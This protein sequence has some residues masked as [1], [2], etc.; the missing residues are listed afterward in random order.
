MAG[1][2][3][4]ALALVVIALVSFAA[5]ATAQRLPRTATPE[6]Y[7]L[8]F[9]VDI[10]HARFEGTETIRVQVDV[11][12]TRIVVNAA[13]IHFASVTI[14]AGAATQT[15]AVTLDATRDTATFVVPTTLPKGPAAIHIRYAGILN[16][17]LRGFYLSAGDSRN[18]A[19]T[20]FESTDARRA[21]P[22]FDEPAFKA[23]F[24]VTLTID[25]SDMAI[26][27]GRVIADMPGPGVAQHTVT[28]STTP[29][30]SS[31]LV[32]MAVG[33]FECLEA[34]TDGVPIRICTSP[35]KTALGQIALQSAQQILAYYNA[36][37]AIRYPYGKLDVLAVPDF[38]SGAMEN[39]AAIFFREI[40]LLADNRTASTDTRKDIASGL[41]HEMAHQWFG[42]LVTMRWWDDLWLNEGFATW[43]A[44]RPL[45]SMKPEW[46]IP[47]DEAVENQAALGLDALRSTRPVHADVNTPAEI[48]AAFDGI[49]YEKGAAVLRMIERYVG[50]ATFRDGINAYLQAHSYGNATSQDFWRAIATTSGK[51]I[52]R[53]M[54]T[55]I[56]QPGAPL[57]SV[58]TT[59]VGSRTRV[60]LHQQRFFVDRELLKKGSPERWQIPVCVT[61]SGATAATC[62]VLSQPT[63]TLELDTPSCAST[64]SSPPGVFANAGAAGYYRTAYAPEALR[65]MAP[66]VEAELTAPE[67]LTLLDDAWTL[68]Q[69]GLHSAADYLTVAAAYGRESASGVLTELGGHLAFIDRYLTTGV[70]RGPFDAF[71]RTTARPLFDAL[72]FDPAPD[73]SDERRAV[74]AAVI[75]IL[76]TT[77]N[78]GDVAGA[79]RQALDRALA[80]GPPLDPTVAASIVRVAAEHGDARLYNALMAAS[81]GA[82]SPNERTMYLNAA[83]RFQDTA[84]IDRALQ[85]A[86]RPDMRSQ[87]TPNYLAGF[88]SNPTAR[89]RAWAFVKSNWSVLEPKL[90]FF[91]ANA[92]I[93]RALS[94]F[95]DAGARDDITAFFASHPL[96][97]IGMSLDQTVERINS[98]IDLTSR[99]TQAVSAWL[100]AR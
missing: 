35:G 19:V 77:G 88:F 61:P 90:S 25:R 42:D 13:E 99:E 37:F 64:S 93:V 16:D 15:A 67:R 38:A 52:D 56:N 14:D 85:A 87:D 94:A 74:R 58:S 70:T 75:E 32:A 20:Q 86:L 69:A 81:Q 54:P 24:D 62:I 44:N 9:T 72:G 43:M 33:N 34:T 76:G 89:P 12:T 1:R 80:G 45:A 98:C 82:A 26:S 63:Q 8:A 97:D 68:V 22:C 28:F 65:A 84:V 36:Y 29:Q 2:I 83:S 10:P 48:D 57:V 73:E 51:P 55:F 47:V 49:A 41:A 17:K 4:A 60:T 71:A 53:I 30:M 3:F 40:D 23:T 7:D 11:P 5:P 100:A 59:C 46:N 18:Y 31:Y 91:D 50:A 39:T 96:A 79:A 92:T 6:H 66:R 21:F 95:C 78:D 27:N